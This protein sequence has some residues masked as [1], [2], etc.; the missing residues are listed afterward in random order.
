MNGIEKSVVRL[1]AIDDD[2]ATLEL[3]ETVLAQDGLEIQ[4][5][6]DP[7]LGLSL[8]LHL[9]PHIVLLDLLMPKIGGM[10]VLER[11]V[12]FDPTTEVI[13][14]TGGYS[15]ESAVEAIRKGASDYLTKPL[16][17]DKLRLRVE[18]LVQDNLRAQQAMRLDQELVEAYSFENMIGRSAEMLQVYTRIRR[19]APHFRTALVSGP[20]GTGKELVARALHRLSPAASGPFAV[21]NCAAV[22]ETL[23]ESELFG[24]LKGAFTGATQDRIG[25]FEYADGGT[26]LLDEIG[27]MP[28]PT[29]SKLLRVLQTQEIQRVGSPSTR[30]VDVRVVVA[31]N[32]D[33]RALAASRQFREDLY[34]RL[35]MVEIQLPPLA[36]RMEDL[37]LLERHFL[38]HF[39]ALYKKPVATLT[40]R[41]QAVLGRHDW[42]GNVRELQ[43]VFGLACMMTQ[44]NTIDVADLPSYL[45][46]PESPANVEDESML[47][48]DGLERR[49]ARRVLERVGGNKVRA[50]RVLGVSRAT[51][52]RLLS[53][54]ESVNERAA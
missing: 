14:M 7:E 2:P 48:L 46:K 27:E 32:R 52:Y 37:P 49:H 9:R 40:R 23:V 35:S 8:V 47:P 22:V 4:T 13:L 38:E 42:P 53:V 26:L 5:A 3:I 11:I 54:K 36:E 41:A 45:S 43:N 25:L 33:L 50:A 17:V 34:Y 12:Q 39:A 51:F 19:V 16:D 44:G 20:T 18:K 31:T 10:R 30:K 29:Q 1:L 28:L 6:A 15:T 24:S 21:C